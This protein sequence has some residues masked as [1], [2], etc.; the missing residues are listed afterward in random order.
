[1]ADARASYQSGHCQAFTRLTSTTAD[2]IDGGQLVKLYKSW[3]SYLGSSA[4]SAN[5]FG[6]YPVFPTY[7][8]VTTVASIDLAGQRPDGLGLAISPVNPSMIYASQNHLVVGNQRYQWINYWQ[9]LYVLPVGINAN[10]AGRCLGSAELCAVFGT[11]AV[12]GV[13][14]VQVVPVATFTSTTN[15]FDFLTFDLTQDGATPSGIGTVAGT[16]LSEYAIDAGPTTLRLVVTENNQTTLLP[17][18]VQ[19]VFGGGAVTTVTRTDNV[20][21]LKVL[22]NNGGEWTVAADLPLAVDGTVSAVRFL[23]NAAFV[24]TSSGTQALYAVDLSNELAPRLAGAMPDVMRSTYFHPM[25][26][27][28]TLLA[29][30]REGGALTVAMVDI[31]NLDAPQVLAKTELDFSGS[32]AEYDFKSFR[33]I[34]RLGLLVLPLTSPLRLDILAANR[35]SGFAH[36]GTVSLQDKL[37]ATYGFGG[38]PRTM[39]FDDLLVGVFGNQDVGANLGYSTRAPQL[40]FAKDLNLVYRLRSVD[41]GPM[42][43]FLDDDFTIEPKWRSATL[44]Q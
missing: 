37:T 16:P 29:L 40:Q 2:A 23:G 14:P 21:K 38:S 43:W 30:G 17:G 20:S 6:A 8:Y 9:R 15:F 5:V 22:Q 31:E 41:G 27:G 26:D 7:N 13:V 18:G 44:L 10:Q 36:Y 19:Q 12:S 28:K 34:P 1:M 24:A 25:E 4:V 35:D 3:D 11:S 33:F 32:Q 39:L 42:R